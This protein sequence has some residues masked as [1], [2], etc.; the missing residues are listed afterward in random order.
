MTQVTKEL[1]DFPGG[2]APEK[3]QIFLSGT[4][5]HRSR[6]R[7]LSPRHATQ[8]PATRPHMGQL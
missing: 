7:H 4:A 8:S 3:A 1:E 6:R 2:I 5:G